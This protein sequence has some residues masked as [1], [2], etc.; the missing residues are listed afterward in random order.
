MQ[1][2]LT[3]QGIYSA[4]EVILQEVYGPLLHDVE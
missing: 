2:V 3:M 4:Y 1:L